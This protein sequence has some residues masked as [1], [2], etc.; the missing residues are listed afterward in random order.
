[1]QVAK[2]SPCTPSVL[3]SFVIY[4]SKLTNQNK[5]DFIYHRRCRKRKNRN[6]QCI[7]SCLPKWMWS[8]KPWPCSTFHILRSA[9]AAASPCLFLLAPICRGSLVYCS[10]LAPWLLLSVPIAFCLSNPSTH[11]LSVNSQS[12]CMAQANFNVADL[13][14]CTW[15]GVTAPHVASKSG[16]H[17]H[18]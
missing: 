5:R 13:I 6:S 1:M 10:V 9:L 7:A 4:A 2:Y 17:S 3:C 14:Y 12:E 16:L 15:D 8:G 11:C 18:K